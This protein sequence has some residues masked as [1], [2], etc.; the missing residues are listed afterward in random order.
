MKQEAAVDKR[1][2]NKDP[3]PSTGE[4][5]HKN[6]S[7]SKSKNKSFFYTYR[8]HI[9]FTAVS[10]S[11]VLYVTSELFLRQCV[12][13]ITKIT[14]QQHRNR[15]DTQWRLLE[16]EYDRVQGCLMCGGMKFDNLRGKL[17]K[18]LR[19]DLGVTIAVME[20]DFDF[21]DVL[22]KLP[23]HH[24]VK[25]WWNIGEPLIVPYLAFKNGEVFYHVHLYNTKSIVSA[26]EKDR[27][28]QWIIQNLKFENFTYSYSKVLHRGDKKKPIQNF[29]IIFKESNNFSNVRSDKFIFDTMFRMKSNGWV[30]PYIRS[31]LHEQGENFAQG[32]NEH[33]FTQTHDV[34]ED[35][36]DITNTSISH[37]WDFHAAPLSILFTALPSSMGKFSGQMKWLETIDALYL[38]IAV[39]VQLVG[40]DS[41]MGKLVD[42]TLAQLGTEGWQGKWQSFR[43][44]QS[45][46]FDK[47]KLMSADE[48]QKEVLER[49][50]NVIAAELSKRSTKLKDLKWNFWI[51]EP[52]S[53]SNQEGKSDDSVESSK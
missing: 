11:I 17:S 6:N 10:L 9:V 31:D 37:V 28:M 26:T 39:D 50:A 24:I 48:Y 2:N 34:N 12:D 21:G 35:K 29:S 30:L 42:L 53:Q 40:E 33:N 14:I 20:Q 7:D 52:E 47:A 27:K 8:M 19:D 18:R 23:F 22:T 46:E 43:I 49:V 44:N 45:L 32:L 4:K 41:W 25:S 16:L 51:A 1:E 36:Q 5:Q 13:A 3:S 15:K 38:D